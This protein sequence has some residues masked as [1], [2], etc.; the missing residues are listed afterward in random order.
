[1]RRS[2]KPGRLDRRHLEA[3]AQLV[4]D[5]GRERLALDVLGDDEER[6]AALCDQF[7]DRQHRL[8]RG[9]LLLVDEDVGVLELDDHLLSI[10]DEVWG[11]IAAVELHALD[12]VELGLGG[13][14]LFDRYHA[15]VADFLHRLGDHLAD[16]GVAIRGNRSDLSD[17]LGALH[18]LGAARDVLHDRTHGNVDAALEIHRVHAGRDQ[19]DS[20]LHDRGGKHRR[21]RSAVAGDVVGLRGHFAHH[22]GAHVLEL[23]G[24][25][26]LLRDR[27]A[28]FGNAGRPVG[29]VDHD[30]AALGA[31]GDFDGVVENFDASQHAI[32]SI[33]RESYVFR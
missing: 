2:P 8:E 11:E 19:L 10:G 6:L 30:V 4:D 20:L 9:Q 23:I 25:L 12:D 15:L 28:V 31:K 22:L 17:L 14:R 16:R 13:F 24:K 1:M 21:G 29:L 33:G 7:E 32:A 5:E 26:D 18:L 27:Y 3:A